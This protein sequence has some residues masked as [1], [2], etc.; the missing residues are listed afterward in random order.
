MRV[1]T[2]LH[3][4][5][6]NTT[7]S[8]KHASIHLRLFPLAPSAST[9]ENNEEGINPTLVYNSNPCAERSYISPSSR[10]LLCILFT[11]SKIDTQG[12]ATLR[13][14]TDI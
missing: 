1:S 5:R 14:I 12:F 7:P 11:T 8:T 4:D 13:L 10:T 3:E 9:Q 2:K 6:Y